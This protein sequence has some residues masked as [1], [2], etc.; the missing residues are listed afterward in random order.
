MTV[1]ERRQRPEKDATIA[2]GD[3]I[4]GA[5]GAGDMG[6]IAACLPVAATTCCT[7]A[8]WALW[9]LV[10]LATAVLLFAQIVATTT[11]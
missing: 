9:A 5:T 1:Q 2:A 11:K 8:P 7:W 3:R 6:V 10:L 4:A